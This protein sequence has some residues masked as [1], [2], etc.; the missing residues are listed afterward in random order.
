[1]LT[2]TLIL[3]VLIPLYLFIDSSI[4]LWPPSKLGLYSGLRSNLGL[5]KKKCD[6]FRGEWVPYPN[7]TYYTNETCP[8]IDDQQNCL[9]F[10]RPDTEFLRWRWK[11]DSCELARFDAIEFLDIVKGKSMAFVGDSVGRNQMLSLLC[12]LAGVSIRLIHP[13][14]NQLDQKSLSSFDTVLCSLS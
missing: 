6:V 11:P 13:S 7:A 2:P 8:L 12:L 1:M 10:G 4:P 14:R 3:L 5:M 9:K